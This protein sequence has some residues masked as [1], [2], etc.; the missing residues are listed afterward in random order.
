MIA[1]RFDASLVTGL[2]SPLITTNRTRERYGWNSRHSR[3][4][5]SR[6]VGKPAAGRAN[7]M[8]PVYSGACFFV[9]RR[10]VSVSS[11]ALIRETSSQ[12]IGSKSDRRAAMSDDD[13]KAARTHRCDAAHRQGYLAG[14][15]GC[16]GADNPYENDSRE[17]RAW[18]MGLLDG[19][20]RQLTVVLSN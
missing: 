14:R 7:R 1:A 18:I 10:S 9:F 4:F 15:R 5:L 19:R 16:T 11:Q 13:P 8:N 3:P 2:A 17:A 6:L 20:T 12:L